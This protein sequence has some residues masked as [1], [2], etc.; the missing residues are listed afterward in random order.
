MKVRAFA[1]SSGHV[2]VL[3]PNEKMRE[4]GESDDN[5][6]ARIAA[7]DEPTSEEFAF[8]DVDVSELP[9]HH[10]L[11]ADGDKRMVRDAW[12]FQNGVITVDASKIPP[13]WAAVVDRLRAELGDNIELH[14][15]Q[16]DH[17]AEKQNQGLMLR[18]ARELAPNLTPTKRNK[19][20]NIL[21]NKGVGDIDLTD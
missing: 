3:V 19:L 9:V 14:L 16:F 18:I 8:V 15:M 21:R 10:D 13:N 2:H 20:R 4:R 11:D 7:K 6:I 17:A 5:F 12:R 1:D